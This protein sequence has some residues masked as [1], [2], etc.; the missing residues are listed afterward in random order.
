MGN[1]SPNIRDKLI[2]MVRI[3][4]RYKGDY[5]EIEFVYRADVNI[6]EFDY[7]QY[8]SIDLGLDN[9]ATTITT[10]E[11]AFIIEGRGIKSYNRWWNKKRA[12]LQSQYDKQEIKWGNKM[13]NIGVKRYNVMRNFIAQSVNKIIRHC[14]DHKIG[15]IVIGDWDDMKRGLKMRK[16]TAQQFQQIP[17]VK[18]KMNLQSKGELFGIN[19]EFVDE[20]YTSQTCSSCGLIR[21]A[22]RVKRGLY[23]CKNCNLQINADINGAINIMRKVAPNSLSK[24]SSGDII[25]P[26]RLKLVNFSV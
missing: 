9:F 10:R 26:D 22:N 8:L 17:Y 7:K 19:V 4:P 25:S 14:V 5:F 3:V 1:H 6:P 2:N 13:T 15:N 23:K 21:K 24:W 16:K 20:A 11:T 12:K 18:F